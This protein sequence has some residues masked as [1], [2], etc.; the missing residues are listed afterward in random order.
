MPDMSIQEGHPRYDLDAVGAEVSTAAYTA[1]A[2]PSFLRPLVEI[3][4][5]RP[6]IMR[7][8]A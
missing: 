7:W 8:K 4:S 6:R 5:V 2:N 1:F 3:Y